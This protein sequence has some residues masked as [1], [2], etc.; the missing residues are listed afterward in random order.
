[1]FASCYLFCFLQNAVSKA[2]EL[3]LVHQEYQRGLHVFEDWLEKE[4]ASLASLSHPEGNVDTLEN[5]LQQLQVETLWSF[6]STLYGYDQR[7]E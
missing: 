5:T 6:M 7:R 3:V 4:Q 2:K 1:M